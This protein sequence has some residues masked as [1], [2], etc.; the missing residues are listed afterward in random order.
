MIKDTLYENMVM[1]DINF[2]IKLFRVDSTAPGV[3]FD[4]HWHE[5]IELQYYTSGSAAVRCGSQDISVVGGD[6][7]V[8]NSNELHWGE[9][10]VT[11][12][13]YYV[14]IFDTSLLQSSFID[15]I[16]SKF[17]APITQ[18]MI[19]FQNLIRGERQIIDNLERII[20]EYERKQTAF[21]IEIKSRILGLIVLLLRSHV[22]RVL[23]EGEYNARTQ[24]ARRYKEALDFIDENLVADISL[25]DLARRISVSPSH[26]CRQFKALT[27]RTLSSY[28]NGKRIDRAAEL[29]AEGSVN[30]SEA[31]LGVGFNDL[32]YFSRLFR[33]YKKVTPSEY[34]RRMAS[35][36][37]A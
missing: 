31:A 2:P 24:N 3:L 13:S 26:F 16:E 20:E 35:G 14:L 12:T 7:L 25:P 33:R 29:L 27:G 19:L 11:G 37:Q 1:P 8:V 4:N 28:I 18:N 23:T 10:K 5:Q 34:K 17:I 30:V 22:Q 36:Q 32:N 15:S 21:E 6:V 9:S